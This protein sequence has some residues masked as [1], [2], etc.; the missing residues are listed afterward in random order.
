MCDNKKINIISPISQN[1]V[2]VV[3]PNKY[4]LGQV[5]V[6]VSESMQELAQDI[7]SNIKLTPKE[8]YIERPGNL[9]IS[10]TISD[11]D[12]IISQITN[13]IIYSKNSSAEE[14]IPD[15]TYVYWQEN[16]KL[17]DIIPQYKG[18]KFLG[19]KDENDEI[20]SE[21]KLIELLSNSNEDIMLF[22]HY[23]PSNEVENP[24]TI[25]KISSSIL[26]TMISLIGLIGTAICFRKNN[27]ERAN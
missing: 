5:I 9:N 7:L 17:S 27:K 4:E 16:I 22:T 19:W 12:I 21:E 2:Y 26:A 15:P 11:K 18:Y 8:K 3:T 20:M 24:N 25:D 6:S 23:E 14:N 13:T 1:S 10:E